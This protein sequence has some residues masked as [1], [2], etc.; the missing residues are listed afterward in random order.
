M[1]RMHLFIICALV[2]LTT[3]AMP[4]YRIVHDYSVSS[5]GSWRLP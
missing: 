1:M 2:D 5:T 3:L 4:P